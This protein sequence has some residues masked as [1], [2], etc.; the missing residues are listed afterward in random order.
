[1]SKYRQIERNWRIFGV[2][3]VVSMIVSFV[4]VIVT[5]RGWLK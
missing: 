2:I 4:M 1:M 3:L 5:S